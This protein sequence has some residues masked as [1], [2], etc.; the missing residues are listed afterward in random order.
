MGGVIKPSAVCNTAAT[1]GFSIGSLV[2]KM[3]S[4]AK[5]M[6]LKKN[7]NKCD[8]P[9]AYVARAWCDIGCVDENVRQESDREL[10]TLENLHDQLRNEFDKVN[11]FTSHVSHTF[12][13][14]S[15]ITL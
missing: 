10:K 6:S 8:L 13:L 3:T 2:D 5:K 9:A 7:K 15:I 14:S 1:A 11:I 4:S 12:N